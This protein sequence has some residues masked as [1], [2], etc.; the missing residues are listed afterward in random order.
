MTRAG[1]LEHLHPSCGPGQWRGAASKRAAEGPALREPKP[2]A[3]G[4]WSQPGT[5]RSSKGP[6][7]GSS[8]INQSSELGSLAFLG[9]GRE[10]RRIHPQQ[11]SKSCSLPCGPT[12]SVLHCWHGP[13]LESH[14]HCL[15]AG[16]GSHREWGKGASG[17]L[18]RC[19]GR[20]RHQVCK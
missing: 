1:F 20:C 10:E 9:Q 19:P 13:A 2:P 8:Q 3:C 18:G 12:R 17:W 7:T 16:N 14:G 6:S 11:E 4:G 15:Q 5:E